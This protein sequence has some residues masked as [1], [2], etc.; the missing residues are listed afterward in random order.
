MHKNVPITLIELPATEY[1]ILNGN[2]SSDVY[3]NFQLPSRAIPTLEAALKADSWTD[4]QSINPVYNGLQGKLTEENQRRIRDSKVLAVSAITR[5]AP[6]TLA[7][8]RQYRQANPSATIIAGGMDPTYRYQQ[9]LEA[10][11]DIVVLGEGERTIRDVMANLNSLETVEGIATTRGLTPKRRLSTPEELSSFPLPIYDKATRLKAGVAVVETS[12]GCPYG[13]DHCAVTDFYGKKYRKKS[14]ERVTSELKQVQGMGSS[15]F[16]I[17]DNLVLDQKH[18][19]YLLN[20][21]ADQGL[22]RPGSS[23][24]V[25]IKA[26]E[27][28]ELLEALQRAG[29]DILYIGIESIFDDS[30]DDLGKPWNA[31]K[32]KNA[33]RLLG[34]A[35]FI[36]H[37]MLMPGGDKDTPERLEEILAWSR[38]NLESVQFFAPMP[39]PGAKLTPRMEEQGRVLTRDYSLYD[40]H[41]IITR[42]IN[43]TPLELQEAIDHMLFSF[44]AK[45]NERLKSLPKEKRIIGKYFRKKVAEGTRASLS[46]QQHRD[47]LEFLRSIS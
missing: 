35:G 42:P 20:T 32:T 7:L 15:I 16:Y 45:E 26:A 21:I 33:I 19:I 2:V 22:A 47:H 9:W 3:S 13:C 12:R 24:Q 17:D 40:G 41:N 10:G 38:T 31:E 29:I 11:V 30:L 25:T 43:F 44:F 6:Q 46:S 14:S 36:R 5:T 28:P 27:N 37:G 8:V 1:G 34:E 23:A 4:V 18:T 39:L